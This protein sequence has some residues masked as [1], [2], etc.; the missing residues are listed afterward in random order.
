MTEITERPLK[1]AMLDTTDCF[2]LET[3]DEVVVWVGKKAD[4]NEKK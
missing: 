4:P 2:I 3:Y 1:K